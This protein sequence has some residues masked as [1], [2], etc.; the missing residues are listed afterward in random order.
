[1]NTIS[2]RRSFFTRC[3]LALFCSSLL[4][5]AA[6]CALEPLT[7]SQV[8]GLR[9][10][11]FHQGNGGW[12]FDLDGRILFD[13]DKATLTRENRAI[14]ARVVR[15]LRDLRIH[16]IYVEG[17]ADSTGSEDYNENLSLRRAEAVA[18]E[19]ERHG[20][21][22]R[23]IRVRGYGTAYPVAN[24]DTSRGRALNRRVVIVVPD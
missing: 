20:W 18:Y 3:L 1:M 11:G 23:A 5:L 13:T 4:F 12:G 9:R 2:I 19:I 6:G 16:H 21:P 8:A 14:I 22:R 10:A 15:V 17:Y 24:N 7:D